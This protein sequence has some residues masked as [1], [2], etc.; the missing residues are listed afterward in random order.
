MATSPAGSNADLSK[1]FGSF[2]S[3]SVEELIRL[4]K[5]SYVPPLIPQ[6]IQSQFNNLIDSKPIEILRAHIRKFNPLQ[7][8]LNCETKDF[9][10]NVRVIKKELF[11]LSEEKTFINQ[12]A[13]GCTLKPFLQLKYSYMEYCEQEPVSFIDRELLPLIAHN[14]R[15]LSDWLAVDPRDVLFLPNATTALTTIFRSIQAKHQ[16]DKEDWTKRQILRLSICYGAVKKMTDTIFPNVHQLDIKLPITDFR[17]DI[18]QPVR[19]ALIQ[20]GNNN[21]QY[22]LATFDHITSNSAI[23][24]PITELIELCHQYNVPVCIDSA[25]GPLAAYTDPAKEL[26]LKELRVDYY[27]A[28]FHKWFSA[29]KGTAFLY[30]HNNHAERHKATEN[31]ISNKFVAEMNSNQASLCAVNPCISHG[32]KSG[33]TSEFIWQG[34]T[35]YSNYLLVA[36]MLEFWQSIGLEAVKL[37]C[38]RMNQ[39]AV[40]YL[41]TLWGTHSAI[42]HTETNNSLYSTMN[43]VKLPFSS[44]VKNSETVLS[45]DFIQNILFYSYNIECPVKE[46]SGSFYI[47]LSS[48]IYNNYCDYKKLGDAVTQI[49][50][51]YNLQ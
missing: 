30:I 39:W 23:C 8:D 4:D 33:F 45:C 7:H 42:T 46:L 6:Q 26:Q 21:N 11:Y 32:H 10:E 49:R 9:E 24:L 41:C 36:H 1:G 17:V 20:A 15:A 16:N 14:I 48:Y 43:C 28:N 50:K 37:Y 22:I 13:F 40:D 18:V 34:L 44:S 3:V 35:D 38:T 27:V 51:K 2:H 12:G 19:E 29:P 31:S 5:Q 47:R 25:H